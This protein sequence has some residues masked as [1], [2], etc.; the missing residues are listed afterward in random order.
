MSSSLLPLIS[1]AQLEAAVARLGEQISVDYAGKPLTILAILT[2]SIVFVAD[3][4]R[5]ITLPH[6]LGLVQASSYRGTATT[7]G[8]LRINTEFL[9][10]VRGRD[11]LLVDDIL[12]TGQ[13]LS[14]IISLVERLEP[15]SIRTAVL[16]WKRERTRVELEPDYVCFD[17]PDRFVVGYGLDFNGE[18]R[19]LPYIGVVE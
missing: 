16:L 10:D 8:S 1:T 13:T 7:P 3:L 14:G 15:T 17:I 12:D 9:P 18:H 19:H 6:Q 4:M 2:G 11:V 5:Q